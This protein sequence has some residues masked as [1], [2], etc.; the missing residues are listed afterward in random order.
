MKNIIK[1]LILSLFIVVYT[2]CDTDV[3]NEVPRD[4]FSPD[5]LYANTSGFKAATATL[6][7]NVRSERSGREWLPSM[8]TGTDVSNGGNTF[9]DII[10]LTTYGAALT[11]S[12]EPARL[13]WNLGY[14]T[15]SYSNLIIEKAQ[16]SNIDW[17][18]PNDP[19]IFTAEAKFF[20]AYYHNLLT[21]LFN[22]IPLAD[23]FYTQPKLDFTRSPQKQV[24]EFI[25][26]DLIFASEN[27]PDNPASVENGKLTSWAALHLLTEVYLHLGEYALAESTAK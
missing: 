14:Q 3:L 19:L 26:E 8:M 16:D 18:N 9:R 24:L 12:F 22:D 1:I 6:Y 25:K 4:S 27:L 21:N 11:P 5:N 23:E 13:W 2:S 20:R 15:I 7:S 10:P 17:D